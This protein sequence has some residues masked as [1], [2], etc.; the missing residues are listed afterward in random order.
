MLFSN[1]DYMK[2]GEFYIVYNTISKQAYPDI[3]DTIEDV[4]K[5]IHKLVK[6]KQG[7]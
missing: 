6:E 1:Y 2:F 3:I 4:N 7:L 5:L